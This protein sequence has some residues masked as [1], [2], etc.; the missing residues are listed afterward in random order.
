MRIDKF[1]ADALGLTRSEARNIIKKKKITVDNRIITSPAEH[2]EGCEAIECG[3]EPL[4][5]AEFIYLMMNKPSGYLSATEDKRQKTVLDL[6]TENYRRYNLFPA[7]RLDKDTEGFLLL[8]N[9]G[10]LAHN[11]LSPKKKVEKK[12]FACL[13]APLE[14]NKIDILENGVDIGDYVTKPCK[15]EKVSDSEVY[16]TIIEGK[17]HQVK[18][19]FEAVDNRVEY[20]KRVTFAGL[21]LD[22]SLSAGQYRQLCTKELEKIL[23]SI[24]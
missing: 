14:K 20:L 3:G 2:V 8:T 12:Y 21:E 11:V 5:R 6:L 16:I 15:V 13:A 18:R 1:V 10:K 24:Q 23:R 7:G 22:E 19:M 9:D 17:F 4:E